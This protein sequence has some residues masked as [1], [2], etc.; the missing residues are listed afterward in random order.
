MLDFKKFLRLLR[1]SRWWVWLNNCRILNCH[2]CFILYWCYWSTC[3][4]FKPLL[5]LHPLLHLFFCQPSWCR[6]ASPAITEPT[7]SPNTQ[8]QLG[9][10]PV[11][12]APLSDG[13]RVGAQ[14]GV[15]VK[16]S[17]SFINWGG[18][19]VIFIIIHTVCFII[20][21]VTFSLV[22][23]RQGRAEGLC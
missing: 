10:H 21:S 12:C 15:E 2:C 14:Q 11:H 19:L 5:L 8:S 7:P 16:T 6:M 3:N 9:I 4:L 17:S 22:L 18:P 23:E 13:R 20:V 1:W